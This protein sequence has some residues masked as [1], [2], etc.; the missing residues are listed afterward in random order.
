MKHSLE[1][2]RNITYRNRKRFLELFTKLGYGHLTSAFSWA[3]I[4]TVLYY[5][6]MNFSGATPDRMVI[7][8]GHG[9]GMLFPIFEDLNL[10]SREEMEETLKVGGNNM[11]LKKLFYPG[12]DF[13]GGSL[14]IGMAMAVGLA[15]GDKLNNSAQKT[16][17][18]LGDAE[19][20]E[21]AV[22]EAIHFAGH[23]KLDNLI[24]VVDRNFLGCSDFTEHMLK[25]EPFKEK[26]IFS[27]WDVYEVDGHNI[28]V[29]YNALLLASCNGHKKP[30]CII[31]HTKKG[32]GLDYTIDK[33]LLHG[34]MPRREE[35][36]KRAF[37]EL[38]YL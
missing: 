34:F 5:E 6:I 35:E 13:Y 3:E 1:D 22:W 30:Q 38:K 25:L 8:K 28:E 19:C 12:F 23:H 37:K 20:Y 27:D 10:I 2:L 29:V 11:K 7:S 14:G 26:W 24:A 18:L 36:I 33:P 9:A 4:S 21:G 31:A 32:G 15:K 16:Y 17:C